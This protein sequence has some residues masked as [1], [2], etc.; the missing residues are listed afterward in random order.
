MPTV[1]A[2]P[3]LAIQNLDRG[4]KRIVALVEHPSPNEPDQVTQALAR[5]LVVRT[6]GHLE[7]TVQDTQEWSPTG[8][9]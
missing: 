3:S 2:W 6:C 9:Y 8:S 7:K 4:L 5:F 1:V